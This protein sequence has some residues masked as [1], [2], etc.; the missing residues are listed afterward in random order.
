MNKNSTKHTLRHSILSLLVIGFFII[1]AT[2]SEDLYIPFGIDVQKFD[3]GGGIYEEVETHT[4]GS[5]IITR[6][7]P[8]DDEGRWHGWVDIQYSKGGSDPKDLYKERVYMV[9]GRRNG[10]CTRTYPD[11]RVEEEHYLN[12][13]KIVLKKSAGSY[14]AER[15]AFEL[16]QARYPWYLFMLEAVQ[17][18]NQHVGNYLDTLEI[19][20]N[21]YTFDPMEFDSYYDQAVDTLR[22]THYDSL[23]LFTDALMISIGVKRMKDDELRLAVI[24]HYRSDGVPT[25]SILGSSYPNY[26]KEMNAMGVNAADLEVFCNDLDDSLKVLGSPD[27]EDSFFVDSVDT[28]FYI[29]LLSISET[30]KSQQLLKSGIPGTIEKDGLTLIFENVKSNLHSQGVLTT[31]V[32]VA[33]IAVSLLILRLLEGDYMRQVV[34]DAY[35]ANQDIPGLPTAGTEFVSSNSATSVTVNGYVIE[36]GGADVSERGIVWAEYYNPTVDD[37]KETSGSG[38]GLF[39]VT[40]DGLT[41]GNSY[42]ARSYATNSVGTAYGNLISFE[43]RNTVGIENPDASEFEMKL[44]PN[45]VSEAVTLQFRDRATGNLEVVILD[46]GGRIVY[47]DAVRPA[48]GI[49]RE[50]C[51]DLTGIS[52][53]LYHCQLFE[54]GTP[55]AG[56]E[57]VILR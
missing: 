50:I 39:S 14:S 44:Y 10:I 11:G 31:P 34:Y 41:E 24:D 48:Q 54:N 56:R 13:S 21:S 45:P 30:K 1:V 15:P 8:E 18:D 28:N 27:P 5:Q 22:T 4:M 23:I 26:V 36:E 2:G 51:I 25:F 38:S 40:L 20:L 32:E 12:G 17:F 9:H 47:R 7:G 49:T 16:L 33:D 43:A 35:R 42:Y 37:R 3:N 6:I 29:A 57:L 55:V 53:G 19:L 46:L 52:D